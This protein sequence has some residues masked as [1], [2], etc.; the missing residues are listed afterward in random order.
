MSVT[1]RPIQAQDK[2]S[3][4]RLWHGYCQFYQS[5]ISD[6]VTE[7]TWQRLMKEDVSLFGRVAEKEGDVVG[8]ALC[9]LHEGTWVTT[10]I[11]YLEDLFV[12]EN[13]RGQ[14]IARQLIESLIAEGKASGWSRLYWHTANDNPARALYEKFI[15]ADNTVRYRMN[16]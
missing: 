2:P 1:I 11:C 8:F 3:W 5:E 13:Q 6:T 12:A 14:G 15:A 7:K 10:P 9:V 16:L 4:L